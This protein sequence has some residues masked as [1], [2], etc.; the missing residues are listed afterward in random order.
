MSLPTAVYS[1]PTHD[2]RVFTVDPLKDRYRTTQGATTGPSSHVL[3]AGQIDRD[4]PSDPKIGPSGEPTALSQL[5]CQLTGLQDDINEFLTEE[6]ELV[7]VKKL[8]T[9][10]SDATAAKDQR[11]EK[12]IEKLLDGDDG[13]ED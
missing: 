2:K 12:E 5:R 6:M 10:S 11:F 8:K 9:D 4:C 13:V 1:S 7:K 3:Q